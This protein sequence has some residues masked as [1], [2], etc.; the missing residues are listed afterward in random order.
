M[1]RHCETWFFEVVAIS[2]VIF[3][4]VWNC[5]IGINEMLIMS[6]KNA[7]LLRMKEWLNEIAMSP[8]HRT[9]GLLAMTEQ[10]KIQIP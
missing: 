8:N 5:G 10:E 9:V 2:S 3:Y 7:T 4:Y 1:S 6:G